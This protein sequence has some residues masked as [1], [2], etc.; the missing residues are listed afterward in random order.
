MD[1]GRRSAVVA[2]EAGDLEAEGALAPGLEA[3]VLK[4]VV[5]VV[6]AGEE[7][8]AEGAALPGDEGVDESPL[9]CRPLLSVAG[10][11]DQPPAAATGRQGSGVP[12][13]R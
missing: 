2:Q 12:R 9:E 8:R 13:G 1:T 7:G 3:G 5:V 4:W 6:E 11:D 10:P